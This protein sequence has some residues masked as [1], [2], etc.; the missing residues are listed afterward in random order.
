[1]SAVATLASLPTAFGGSPARPSRRI[2]T[3]RQVLLPCQAVRERDFKLIADR[4]VD[5]S[6][7][8]MLV[9]L[10][11]D[12]MVLTGETILVSFPIPGLWI[13]AEA[14]VTRIVHGRRPCDDG[15]AAG[16]EFDVISPSARAA[17]AG[18]LHGRPPPLPRR[19]PLARLHRGEDAPQLADRGLVEPITLSIATPEPPVTVLEVGSDDVDDDFVD[20]LGVLRELAAAWKNLVVPT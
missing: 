8:G 17:L 16:L 10:N 2:A 9:P 18:Y 11:V 3:R 12:E 20:G 14:T 1:M 7:E 5:V 19:G 13:D 4:T 15:L 6:I